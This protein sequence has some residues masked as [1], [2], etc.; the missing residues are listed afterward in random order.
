MQIPGI[1]NVSNALAAIL[2]ARHYKIAQDV[3]K[4]A[5]QRQTVPGRCEN[6]RISDK[7]VFLVDYAHNEMSL[8]NLLGTCLLYTSMVNLTLNAWNH[9]M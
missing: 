9:W 2:V 5:L 4:D 3:V 6:V 7:F 1:F 8:R